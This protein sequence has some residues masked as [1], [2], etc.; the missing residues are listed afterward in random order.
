MIKTINLLYLQQQMTLTVKPGSKGIKFQHEKDNGSD[1][2]IT[3]NDPDIATPESQG[4]KVQ[5]DLT[6]TMVFDSDPS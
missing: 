3:I 2:S 4:V 6:S 5:Y 1:P